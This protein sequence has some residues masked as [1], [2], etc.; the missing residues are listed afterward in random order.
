MERFPCWL[1]RWRIHLPCRR[2]RRHGFNPW[3][4]KIPWRRKWQPTPVFLSGESQGQR[5]LADYS[6]KGY[7][8]SDITKCACTHTLRVKRKPPRCDDVKDNILQSMLSFCLSW[9]VGLQLFGEFNAAK[10]VEWLLSEMD[11][12]RQEPALVFRSF[13]V[14][15]EEELCREVSKRKHSVVTRVVLRDFK[16]IKW[17]FLNC[18]KLQKYPMLWLPRWSSGQDSAI[19]MLG[20]WVRS[21]VRELRSHMPCS[22]D[23]K[24]KKIPCWLQIN[25]SF[26]YLMHKLK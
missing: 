17:T 21:L 5:S 19:P 24:K 3:V 8:D 13:Q 20:M 25:P 7:K 15:D 16:G 2:H 12:S 18:L 14:E 23:K 1:S 11:T 26:K 4:G 6:P 9:W 10:S 22:L